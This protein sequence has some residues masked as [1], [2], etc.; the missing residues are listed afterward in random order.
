MTVMPA[1]EV[2][3]TAEA[4]ADA[5]SVVASRFMLEPATYVTGADLGF[6]GFSFYFAGRAGVLG[7][8]DA[9]VV[10]AALVFFEPSTVR[11]SWELVPAA[12][13]PK[14]GAARYLE[15]GHRWARE[16]IPESIDLVR[17]SELAGRVVAGA[18]VAN[19]PLFAG[20]RR[21]PEPADPPA[22]ALHRLNLLRELRMARHG[23]AV[24]TAGLHPLEA[25]AVRAPGMIPFF[26]WQGDVPD[27]DPIRATWEAAEA[28][29]NVAMAQAF[30]TL[31][32]AE[33][34]EFVALG[35]EILEAT[36]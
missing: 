16:R 32:R 10:A 22:L 5:V 20:W 11:E 7:D 6:E 1:A 13:S 28:A 15:C 4:S 36:A 29:T 2:V 17:F 8:V 9:D 33:R 34:D 19:A 21:M 3:K 12:M 24:L 31:E 26:G 18:L 14:D 35:D 30:E 27:P 23:A 25:M